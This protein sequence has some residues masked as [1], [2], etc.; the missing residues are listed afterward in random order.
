MEYC[1][2]G[3]VAAF[4]R[5]GNTLKEDEIREIVACSLMGLSYLHNKRIIHRV[6]VAVIWL[7]VRM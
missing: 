6:C 3:S 5:R 7:S 1:H 2:C 4:L